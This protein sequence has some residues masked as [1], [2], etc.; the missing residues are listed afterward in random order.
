MS[1]ILT[2]NQRQIR[3]VG[4]MKALLI[5]REETVLRHIVRISILLSVSVSA[6]IAQPT[7]AN[8]QPRHA[9]TKD[10]TASISRTATLRDLLSEAVVKGRVRR[11]SSDE[12]RPEVGATVPLS[13]PLRPL[14][15]AVLKLKPAWRGYEFFVS[16]KEVAIVQPT[17]S[18]IVE[19]V[20][21]AK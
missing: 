1:T 20:P 4:F 21:Y 12:V 11:A 8:A 15:A 14:P 7:G 18:K 9:R 3:I 10:T 13:I 16:G 6:A 19:L 5:L 2:L 17:T